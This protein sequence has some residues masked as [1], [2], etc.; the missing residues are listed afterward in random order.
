MKKRKLLTI[1]LLLFAS[2]T[3]AQKVIVY[4]NY[5]E[6]KNGK[7]KK[8]D[9]FQ[10]MVHTP[11]GKYRL[12]VRAGGKNKKIKC[13]R[14]WG[15]LLENELFRTYGSGQYAML[16]S[17]GKLFYFENGEAYLNKGTFLVGYYN[18][19]SNTVDG[20]LVQLPKGESKDLILQ[21]YENFKRE[22][23]QH[24]KFFD[25]FDKNFDLEICRDCMDRYNF[26]DKIRPF[27]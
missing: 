24:K 17:Q 12:V 2:M 21:K 18:F 27:Q 6:Y 19:I 4:N 13:E 22:N 16:V 14:I 20:E 10:K 9:S 26:P 1:L 11:F 5:D 15:F 23:P 3:F 7:G 25:C 8:Y